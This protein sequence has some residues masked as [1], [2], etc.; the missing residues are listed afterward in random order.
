MARKQSR[1]DAIVL[2]RREKVAALFRHG[3]YNQFEIARKLLPVQDPERPDPKYQ[4]RLMT[5]QVIVSKDLKWIRAQWRET[6]IANFQE[7]INQQVELLKDMYRDVREQWERSKLEAVEK[8]EDYGKIQVRREESI[9][10]PKCGEEGWVAECEVCGGSGKVV[11]RPA[12]TATVLKG[13]KVK[14]KGRHGDPSLYAQM[15]ATQDK[16][17]QM[18][19]L[20][21]GKEQTLVVRG[22]PDNPVK[23]EHQGK[24][25]LEEFKKLSFEDKVAYMRAQ[26]AGGTTG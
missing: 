13:R 16:I 3:V 20:M 25:N 23:V 1:R 10:C 24:I 19:G 11:T 5:M 2:M 4:R 14:K 8:E 26:A 17:C 12:E 7:G 15:L 18:L 21:P 22:D 6:A 9:P